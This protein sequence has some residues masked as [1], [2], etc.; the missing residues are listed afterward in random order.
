MTLYNS[1]LPYPRDLKGYGPKPPHAQWPKQA[2]IAV[3]FVLNYE[4]GGEA[5]VLHGDTGPHYAYVQNGPLFRIGGDAAV[6]IS[7]DPRLTRSQLRFCART[8]DAR[9]SS[10][11]AALSSSRPTA[12]FW[13]LSTRIWVCAAIS[14]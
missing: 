10:W 12:G 5:C 14:S 8:T 7:D 4:E 6:P 1:T 11:R 13:P 9:W 2:R 3:Q